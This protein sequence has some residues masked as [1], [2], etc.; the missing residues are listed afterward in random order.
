MTGSLK[1]KLGILNFSSQLMF[2]KENGLQAPGI[3][4]IIY[5]MT[6]SLKYKRGILNSTSQLKFPDEDVF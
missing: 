2:H 4:N 3:L 6:G 5:K 1:Y